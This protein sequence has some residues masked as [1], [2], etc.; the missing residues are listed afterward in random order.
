MTVTEARPTAVVFTA[1]SNRIRRGDVLSEAIAHSE[2]PVREFV[3]DEVD[4]DTIYYAPEHTYIPVVVIIGRDLRN[5]QVV[6]HAA[7]SRRRWLVSRP[8][9]EAMR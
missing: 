7:L 4:R 9:A 1:R 3:V 8:V 2:H 5:G 6:K